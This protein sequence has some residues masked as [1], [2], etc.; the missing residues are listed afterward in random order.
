MKSRLAQILLVLAEMVAALVVYF[1]AASAM[2][3]PVI[4]HRNEIVVGGGELGGWLWRYWW[5]FT[6]ADALDQLDVSWVERWTQLIALGRHPETGNILDVLFLSWPLSHFMDFPA[7]Y[8]VKVILVLTLDGLCGYVL[9]RRFVRSRIVA[10]AAGLV[11]VVNPLNVQDINGSGLRQTILWWLLLYPIFLDRA[12]RRQ[13][14][15]DGLLAGLCAG[16]AASWYWFYGLFAGIFTVIYL[17]WILLSRRV[18][19]RGFF[20]WTIPMVVLA[21]LVAAPFVSPYLNQAEGA[22]T[23]PE[24]SFFLPFPRYETIAA[25]PLRPQTYQENVLASLHRTVRSSWAA[26]YILYPT[27]E[28]TMPVAVLFLGLLPALVRRRNLFWAF[29]YLFFYAASLGPFLKL[30]TLRDAS[31]VFRI[32]QD[33]VVRMPFAWLFHWVPGMSR[34]FGPYRLASFAIVAAVVLLAYGLAAIPASSRR[35]F[36]LRTSVCLLAMGLTM[37]QALYRFEVE[38]VPEGSFQPSRWR[39]PIKVSRIVVPD[40]YQNLD[41]TRMEGIIELPL[42]REQDLLCYYQTF[43]RQKVYRSWA[44]SGAV[45]PVLAKNGGGEPGARLR[46]LVRQLPMTFPGAEMLESISSQPEK[47]EIETIDR[48]AVGKLAV[49]GAYRYLVVHERGYYLVHP[50][51]GPV[52]Y[53]DAVDRLIAGLKLEP[54]EVIEHS[55]VDYPGNQYNVPDGP[56]YIPWSAEE[57]SLTDQDMPRKLYMAVFDLSPLLAEQAEEQATGAAA[58]DQGAPAPLENLVGSPALPSETEAVPAGDAGP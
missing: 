22:S 55:W 9:A 29:V 11:A 58:A 14:L 30:E 24:M 10:L 27:S 18:S 51:H 50:H 37:L 5:H 38:N 32:G 7:H 12:A 40:F 1:A 20:R 25:A 53:R 34:L 52:L 15:S 41:S 39:A 4:E 19:M 23:L 6:E 26:D 17:A 2:T 56:V 54:V 33:W 45:P 47:V 57:I 31:E 43:H 36:V 28:R 21:V 42:G 44:T 13:R 49:A 16:M 35:G 46:Y 3:W 8:N 48:N